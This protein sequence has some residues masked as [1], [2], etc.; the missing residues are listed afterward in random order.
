MEMEQSAMCCG[1][2]G[3][4]SV[5]E[6]ELAEKILDRKMK[7][8]AATRAEQVVTANPGCMMQIERGLRS[9]GDTSSVVHVVDVLDEAYRAEDNQIGNPSSA[10]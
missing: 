9:Q 7:N 3:L 2:A 8:I 6:P 10:R 4:Y 1:A 5:T